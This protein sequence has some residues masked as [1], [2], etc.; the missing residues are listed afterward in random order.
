MSILQQDEIKKHLNELNGWEYEDK[1]IVKTF[2]KHNFV[3]SVGFV[4]QVALLS[5]RADHHPDIL[6]QYSK[7]RITLSTHSE[8]G[9][10]EKDIKLAHE[11]ESLEN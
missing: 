8:G 6:L 5:E 7:V 4:T 3:D 9:V 11:I 2:S 1:Q 10:T